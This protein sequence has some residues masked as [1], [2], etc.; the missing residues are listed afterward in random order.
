[1][2]SLFGAGSGHGVQSVSEQ[3]K[4]ALGSTHMF[5]QLF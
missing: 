4:L 1:M 3:P 5:W 2:T